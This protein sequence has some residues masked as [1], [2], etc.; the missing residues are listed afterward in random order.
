MFI[1][2]K[3]LTFKAI[4]AGGLHHDYTKLLQLSVNHFVIACFVSLLFACLYIV[5]N[6]SVFMDL[7]YTIHE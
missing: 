6:E 1:L 3:L 5:D 7:C 2:F 4:E